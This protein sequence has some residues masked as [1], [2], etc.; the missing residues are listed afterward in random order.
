MKN[1]QAKLTYKI[2][3]L[4][5][6]RRS[7]NRLRTIAAGFALTQDFSPPPHV[8]SLNTTLLLLTIIERYRRV[9]LRIL[10]VVLFSRSHVLRLSRSVTSRAFFVALESPSMF[11][12]LVVSSRL[13]FNLSCKIK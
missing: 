1:R 11:V 13:S 6:Y 12:N 2:E 7:G 8:T 5:G 9:T 4:N 3:M 10:A